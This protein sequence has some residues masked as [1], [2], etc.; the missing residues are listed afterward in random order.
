MKVGTNAYVLLS[1]LLP[2]GS[3]APESV[4]RLIDEPL[5]PEELERHGGPGLQPVARGQRRGIEGGQR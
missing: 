4:S 2:D 1:A 5:T 3:V